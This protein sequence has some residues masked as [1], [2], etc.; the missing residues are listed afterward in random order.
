[1]DYRVKITIRNNHIL[2]AMEEQ[3]YPSVSNFCRKFKLPVASVNSVI[4]GRYKPLLKNG[5][6]LNI[7]YKTMI[8]QMNTEINNHGSGI[9]Y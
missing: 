6:I 2:K 4:A 9:Q 3:G 8:L 7:F 5:K 1:M